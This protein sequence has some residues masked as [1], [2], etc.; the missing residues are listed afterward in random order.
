LN[1]PGFCSIARKSILMASIT[2]RTLAFT[3]AASLLCSGR[4]DPFKHSSTSSASFWPE[5]CLD[6]F[7]SRLTRLGMYLI[8]RHTLWLV[9]LI[10]ATLPLVVRG[11]KWTHFFRL[12]RPPVDLAD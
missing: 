11:E 3:F 9:K 10:L 1:Q 12:T 2:A 8:V 5:N 4:A 6:S 7:L